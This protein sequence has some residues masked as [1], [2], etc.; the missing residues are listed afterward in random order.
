VLAGIDLS[1][2]K[3]IGYFNT[4]VIYQSFPFAQQINQQIAD[5]K[6]MTDSRI[7][8]LKKGLQAHVD[9]M[10]RVFD[11]SSLLNKTALQNHLA[12]LDYQLSLETDLGKIQLED[13]AVKRIQLLNDSLTKV[14][15]GWAKS[16]NMGLLFTTSTGTIAFASEKNFN[17]T[18]Q[19]IQD[20]FLRA[21]QEK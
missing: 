8:P 15:Q 3:K 16:Q 7:D 2:A 21:N 10:G 13:F 4:D 1:S 20:V 9:S 19:I 18:N 6:A 12:H 17:L 14:I 11:Q 5:Q